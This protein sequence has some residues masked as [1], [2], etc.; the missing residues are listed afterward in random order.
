MNRY[1]KQFKARMYDRG[2]LFK[3]IA[4]RFYKA[5]QIP[6][7]YFN[8]TYTVDALQ[9]SDHQRRILKRFYG[10]NQSATSYVARRT[11]GKNPVLPYPDT[12][13]VAPGTYR[14]YAVK[15]LII[16]EFT[17]FVDGKTLCDAD[18]FVTLP[19]NDV[20]ITVTETCK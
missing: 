20:T 5:L 1:R 17:R 8:C 11:F 12:V 19:L 6:M 10:E 9:L 14:G 4:K 7:K 3:D 18:N 2:T 16:D 15:E 13:I